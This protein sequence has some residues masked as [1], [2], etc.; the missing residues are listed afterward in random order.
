M[1]RENARQGL[2]GIRSSKDIARSLFDKQTTGF[3]DRR[4]SI[5]VLRAGHALRAGSALHRQAS[6]EFFHARRKPNALSILIPA[7]L[8]E[9]AAL[10]LRSA[11]GAGQA[12]PYGRAIA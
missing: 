7:G 1:C 8:R 4:S 2:S 6:V 3:A 10:P 9:G 11:R 5:S 12:L